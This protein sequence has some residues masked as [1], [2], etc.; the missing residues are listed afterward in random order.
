[1]HT[2]ND[3]GFGTVKVE[4]AVVGADFPLSVAGVRLV[5]FRDDVLVLNSFGTVGVEQKR[6]A[7]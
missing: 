5:P 1:M 3:G 7:P 6:A 2:A 4:S